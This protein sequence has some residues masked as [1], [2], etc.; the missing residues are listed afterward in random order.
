[1]SLNAGEFDTSQVSA[2]VLIFASRIDKVHG[3]PDVHN[4]FVTIWLV[5]A[6]FPLLCG[7]TEARTEAHG[8]VITDRADAIQ[9]RWDTERVTFC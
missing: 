4:D 6:P 2:A 7:E 5:A 1:M 3:I 8:V 9:V